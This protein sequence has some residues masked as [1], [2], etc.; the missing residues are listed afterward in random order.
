M[1]IASLKKTHFLAAIMT[2]TG[3]AAKI[4]HFGNNVNLNEDRI[5]LSKLR[6]DS[7]DKDKYYLTFVEQR[8]KH[9]KSTREKRARTLKRYIKLIKK[10]NGY[11]KT[12]ILKKK[13]QGVIEPRYFITVKF[14]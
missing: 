12:K 2:L 14:E 4:D 6:K 11:H 10:I 9:T 13:S 1:S 5:Y 7:K 3:C 8:G